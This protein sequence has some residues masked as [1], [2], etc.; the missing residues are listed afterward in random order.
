MFNS[1]FFFLPT[2]FIFKRNLFWS[3]KNGIV[4]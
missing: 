4:N 3:T 1:E 2:D